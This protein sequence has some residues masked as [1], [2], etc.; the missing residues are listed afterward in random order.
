MPWPL[1]PYRFCRTFST[2]SPLAC[3][4]RAWQVS[5]L[6]FARA[7]A[8]GP[9]SVRVVIH[10][11]FARMLGSWGSEVTARLRGQDG[12]QELRKV[13]L[14]VGFGEQHVARFHDLGLDLGC[15]RIA[16]GEDDPDRGI[17]LLDLVRES[18]A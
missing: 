2:L 17:A 11:G 1:R 15:A 7:R 12:S 18:D 14:G 13:D 10:G 16:R 4:R 3:P 9:A 5:E 8:S 6:G